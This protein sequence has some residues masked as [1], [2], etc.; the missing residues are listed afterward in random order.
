[1]QYTVYCIYLINLSIKLHINLLLRLR[2]KSVGVMLTLVNFDLFDSLS[3]DKSG[4]SLFFI[5]R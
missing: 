4:P 1:M 5:I 2:L 3:L